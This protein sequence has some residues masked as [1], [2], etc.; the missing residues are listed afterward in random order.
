MGIALCNSKQEV[1]LDLMARL[2][3]KGGRLGKSKWV[4]I[5]SSSRLKGEWLVSPHN[6]GED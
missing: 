1:A 3:G 4:F 5:D 6:Q 2:G